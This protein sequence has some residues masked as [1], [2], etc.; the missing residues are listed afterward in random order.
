ML[1]QYG[2]AQLNIRLQAFPYEAVANGRSTINISLEV[3]RN[4]GTNVPDGTQVLLTTSLGT[5]RE[6]IVRTSGGRAQ[7]VL[8]SGSV[9]GKAKITASELTNQ[10]NPSILEVRFV[11][12]R[13]QLASANDFVEIIVPA[14]FEYQFRTRTLT[15]SDPKKKIRVTH[16][17][18]EF[19]C[20]EVQYLQLANEL[21]A[22]NVI[23]PIKGK[24]VKF[25]EFFL[26][27]QTGRGNGITTI[28][29]REGAV[30]PAYSGT[31][32]YPLTGNLDDGLR[33]ARTRPRLAIVEFDSEKLTPIK[34]PLPQDF[35][36]FRK[37]RF[38]GIKVFKDD[39]IREDDRD[40]ESIT[41]T[42]KRMSVVRNQDIQ[43]EDVKVKQVDTTVWSQKLMSLSTGGFQGDYP[44]QDWF[45][46]TNNQIGVNYPYFLD[47]SRR[48]TSN[49]RFRT[50]QNFG[51]GL[52]VNR[53][54]FFDYETRWNRRDESG[55]SFVYSAVGRD[56][57]NLSLRQIERINDSLLA[58]FSIDSPQLDSLFGVATLTNTQR[59]YQ[60][61]LTTST[62]RRLKGPKAD[63][64][65]Y[66]VVAER[67][68]SRIKGTT[69]QTF[70]GLN[71]GY[72]ESVFDTATDPIKTVNQTV[73]GQLRV[74]SDQVR[75][76]SKTSLLGGATISQPIV[77]STN[78][79]Q[80]SSNLTLSQGLSN[81]A[82]TTWMYEFAQDGQTEQ[83]IGFHR[84]SNQF[85]VYTGK[86][87]L[88]SFAQKSLGVDRLL[89]TAN[90]GYDF[91]GL[92]KTTLNYTYNR[93]AENV[94]VD[95][96][97]ILAY[98]PN[99][100]SPYLGLAYSRETDRIGFVYLGT[101]F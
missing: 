91:G 58:N 64:Q 39:E 45:S 85:N 60:F 20:D 57:Y 15:G 73:S 54:V 88:N 61:N 5:F 50:G 30:F 96:N 12:S 19:T 18:T 42:A 3:R 43:F 80:I 23:Y 81:N 8:I 71:A 10:S 89:L 84:L 90:A 27:L 75:L 95:Y 67:N 69:L 24:P 11:S 76:N 33:F 66:F 35:F 13:D 25:S 55:G 16:R 48:T 31:Y 86:F 97:L 77:G 47:L 74:I 63:T 56:D 34:E 51:T 29:D 49:I 22:K 2:A 52:S 6:S 99:L 4:D 98:R 72:R 87:S 21:R 68:P 79:V 9:A 26:N 83:A 92:W 36:D 82:S 78:F 40:Y 14:G 70:L 94:F 37:T 93:L 1:A 101:R 46:V 41:L 62:N 53:G 100:K 59:D 44:M 7:A 65:D 17:N 38:G 28:E 32:F